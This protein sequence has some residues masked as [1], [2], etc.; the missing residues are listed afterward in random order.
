[1]TRRAD[2]PLGFGRTIAISRLIRRPRR[3]AA[4]SAAPAGVFVLGC[5][6]YDVHEGPA[7]PAGSHKLVKRSRPSKASASLMKVEKSHAEP[8]PRRLSRVRSFLVTLL[9]V[10]FLVLIGVLGVLYTLQDRIIFPGTSTQGRPEASIRPRP[11][12]ELLKLS[13]QKG[14]MVTALYGP[15]LLADG[16]P[17]P[18]ARSRP[19]LLYFY[20]NAMCLAYSEPEFDRFRRL[21]LNVIIPDYLGYGLSSGKP[22]EIGCRQT[23]EAALAALQSRGFPD[24]RIIVGGWSLG[25]AVAIDLASRYPVGG[26]IAFSTFTSTQDMSGRLFPVAL[27]QF[28]FVHRFESLKK[29]PLIACPVLLGH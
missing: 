27:P 26:L 11:G 2:A 20:G 29:M 9:R 14:E 21:G 19:A 15:S 18:Q 24:S 3:A 7:A 12:A 10:L 6:R 16:R 8:F 28:L 25:G 5:S 1:M 23:G 13:T 4:Q 17:D 22:S